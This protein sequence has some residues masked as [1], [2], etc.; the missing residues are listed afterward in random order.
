M[1]EMG[2]LDVAPGRSAVDSA[3]MRGGSVAIILAALVATGYIPAGMP[4]Q[5][6]ILLGALSSIYGLF[7]LRR[8]L[9]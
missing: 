6:M 7:G 1:S 3:T 9:K 8:A 4:E 5:I 2:S